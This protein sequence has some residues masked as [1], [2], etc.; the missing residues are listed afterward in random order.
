MARVLFAGAD[1]RE[2]PRLPDP[3]WDDDRRRGFLLRRDIRR[4]LSIDR[5]VWRPIVGPTGEPVTEPLPW[6]GLDQVRACL[7]RL[8]AEQQEQ[9][10]IVVRGVVAACQDE[11]ERLARTTGIEVELRIDPSW[12]FLGFDIADGDISALCNCRYRDEDEKLVPRAAPRLN[13]YGLF[14]DVEH[15]LVFRELSDRRVPEHAPFIVYA[16]WLA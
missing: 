10:V 14:D 5:L 9:S 16:L 4:P 12:T 1:L 13:D 8:S 7:L 11:E 15:A 6:V 2:T 3:A